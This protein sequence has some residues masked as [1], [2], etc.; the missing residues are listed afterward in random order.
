MIQGVGVGTDTMGRPISDDLRERA[1]AAYVE[2]GSCRA[3]AARFGVGESSVVRWGQLFRATG[4]VSPKPMGVSH[5]SALDP[6]RDWLLARIAEEPSITLEALRR[7]LAARG[8]RVGYGTVWR[9]VDR[10]KLSFKKKR[11]SGRAGSARR[12]GGAREVA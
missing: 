10:E 8:V 6:H 12:G 7:E 5:G 3:V 9:F 1:V 4:S 11:A 2:G